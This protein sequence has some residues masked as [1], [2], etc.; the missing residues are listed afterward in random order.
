MLRSMAAIG[1]LA[2]TMTPVSGPRFEPGVAE[3]RSCHAALEA[4]EGSTTTAPSALLDAIDARLDDERLDGVALGLSLWVE[5]Y[6]EI[7]TSLPDLRL[8]P[9]SNQKILT[10]MGALEVLGPDHR[11]VTEVRAPAPIDGV[12][13]G[14]LS[15]VGGG[16]PTVTT[17]G[18]HSLEALAAQLAAQ[19]V[20]RITGDVV[21]DET[22]YDTLRRHQ[23]WSLFVAPEWVGSLSALMVDEN[24]WSAEAAFLADPA[25]R[26][27]D[28]FRA[29][30]LAAG[31]TVG[32]SVVIGSAPADAEVLASIRSIPVSGLVEA[33]LTDSNNT[34]A[35]MIVKEI[36]Y[37]AAG[38][39]STQVGLRAIDD[40]LRPLCVEPGIL[41]N[42]GSGLS[43]GNFRS[44]RT[45]RNLLTAAHTRD[46][47]PVFVDGLA[48]GGETGTLR[49]RFR[50]TA[51][52]GI[53]RAKTG[54]ISGVRALSGV[55]VTGDGR[56][57][58]FSAIVHTD[59]EPRR[60]IGVIDDL[61]V[62]LAK[63][64][65]PVEP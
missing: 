57:V 26:N 38:T 19:G 58:V 3:I 11:L 25:I 51:A 61:L 30:L 15:L 42:D 21:V 33:M 64:G 22:R 14:D 47:W 65:A 23:S 7:A 54:T 34:Y 31:I 8:R 13:G 37:V 32:G 48:V 62:D 28:L 36:G 44:V 10:A 63:W 59:D 16:D 50:D 20:S 53:V 29:H 12:V 55:S 45:W 39:G 27:G 35:E 56:E 17:T 9:A 60:A 46:W 5:G 18:S 52:E 43:V 2:V 24:R 49:Y 41:Q 6:G 40:A 4:V 1:L